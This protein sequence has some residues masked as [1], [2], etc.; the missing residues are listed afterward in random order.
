MNKDTNC[1]T[2][3]TCSDLPPILAV[4]RN[5]DK[6]VWA[7]ASTERPVLDG[8]AGGTRK[9]RTVRVEVCTATYHNG[10]KQYPN[11][12]YKPIGILHEY[13]ETDTMYFGLLSGS[14]DKHMS[15]G[16]LRKVMSSFT[17]E[18]D[19]DTG[20]FKTVTGIVDTFNKFRIRGYNQS[21]T[22]EEYL[23]D[24][25][26]E[27][28]AKAPTEGEFVDW[29]NPV[30]EMMYEATRYLAGKKSATH[31]FYGRRDNRWPSRPLE[32]RLGR[33]LRHNTAP[34]RH[35]GAPKPTF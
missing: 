34:Q 27:K 18:V 20:I 19:K 23:Q 26:Y 17:N 21:T 4:V 22:S 31:A 2:L 9:N 6:R 5:S 13:G 16:R 35:P 30:A 32:R 11:G 28:S 3:N 8:N 7:W 33:P 25:P 10:C 15:G 14:Y 12:S 24:S 1:S 29:G